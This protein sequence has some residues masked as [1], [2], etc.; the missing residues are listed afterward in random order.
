MIIFF[1]AVCYIYI[2]SWYVKVNF[3]IKI[4]CKVNFYSCLNAQKKNNRGLSDG[5]F[6]IITHQL[7]PEAGLYLNFH[8]VEIHCP[9]LYRPVQCQA[10]VCFSP[11][12]VI[13][14]V[15]RLYFLLYFL[16]Y[17]C[18][19]MGEK[20]KNHYFQHYLKLLRLLLT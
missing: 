19:Q 18:F 8:F 3:T 2:K 4:L 10:S 14:P 12:P 16:N 11:F 5:C 15:G 7:Y 13:S 17:H 9:A 6:Y 20:T 1:K